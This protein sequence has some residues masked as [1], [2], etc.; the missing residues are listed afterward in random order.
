MSLFRESSPGSLFP[1]GNSLTVLVKY[2]LVLVGWTLRIVL[3]TPGTSVRFDQNIQ[4]SYS[5]AGFEQIYISVAYS[6]PIAPRIPRHVNGVSRLKSLVK[7]G[8]CQVNAYLHKG[9]GPKG[10]QAR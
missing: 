1:T 5:S 6:T 8:P 3:L 10:R 7:P 2:V 9:G 4:A